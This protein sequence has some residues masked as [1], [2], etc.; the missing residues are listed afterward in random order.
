MRLSPGTWSLA[1][2]LGI[3]F[4]G[5]KRLYLLVGII[6]ELSLS[7]GS[8]P[9]DEALLRPKEANRCKRRSQAKNWDVATSPQGRRR[10]CSLVLVPCVWESTGVCSQTANSKQFALLDIMV[11]NS[12]L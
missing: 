7:D 11:C 12:L 1:L 8:A 4:S 5:D 2:Q 10:T 3:T 9:K 6:A